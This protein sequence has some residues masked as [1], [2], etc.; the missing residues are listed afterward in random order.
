MIEKQ[1]KINET[2]NTTVKNNKNDKNFIFQ[3]TGIFF[4]RGKDQYIALDPTIVSSNRTSMGVVNSKFK[5]QIEGAE[6]NYTVDGNVVFYFNFDTNKKSLNNSNANQSQAASATKSNYLEELFSQI[7]GG[8]SNNYQAV[9]PNDFRLIKLDVSKGR[10]EYISGK[11]SAFGQ[12]DMS[13]DNKFLINYKYEKVSANTFKIKFESP[14][15]PG[16]YAFLYIG[17]NKSPMQQMYGSNNVKV[18]DFG[19]N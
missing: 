4:E 7:Y 6:A 15:K 9:S 12:F 10:R 3:E 19:V 16:Q 1:G 17:N 13:I 14:L 11:L 8:S 18:F 5:A 2:I